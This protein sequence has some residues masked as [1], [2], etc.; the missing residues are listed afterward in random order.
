MIITINNLHSKEGYFIVNIQEQFR[1]RDGTGLNK[2][3]SMN[4]WNLR[5]GLTRIS[6]IIKLDEVGIFK[7]CNSFLDKVRNTATGGSLSPR[8]KDI[9]LATET[10][11]VLRIA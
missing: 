3:N 4:R 9:E 11:S 5:K 2:N 8:T 1:K 7:G 10:S 6:V